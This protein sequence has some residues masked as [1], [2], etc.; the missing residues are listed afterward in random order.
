MLRFDKL[1]FQRLG[2]QAGTHT[3]TQAVRLLT[4]GKERKKER[5]GECVCLYLGKIE[6]VER[7]VFL[8]FQQKKQ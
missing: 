3:H 2:D 6:K 7:K 8:M 1:G 5:E 4:S